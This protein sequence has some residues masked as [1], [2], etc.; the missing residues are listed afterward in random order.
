MKISVDV[1]SI[2]QSYDFESRQH[3]NFIVFEVGGITVRAPAT[4]EQVTSMI[5]A[6]EAKRKEFVPSRDARAEPDP[7]WAQAADESRID[8]ALENELSYTEEDETI[9]G[10]DLENNPVQVPPQMFQGGLDAALQEASPS[11]PAAPTSTEARKAVLAHLRRNDPAM[12]RK[13]DRAAMRERAQSAPHRP[14]PKDEMG[15]PIVQP[16]RNT[17]VAPVALPEVRI[18]RPTTRIEDADGFEQG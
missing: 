6:V 13:A 17:Q 8:D 5:Q 4:A 1:K 3:K 10:G 16:V 9:F 12:Q 2:E 15:Y 7:E 11:A 18:N 14:P